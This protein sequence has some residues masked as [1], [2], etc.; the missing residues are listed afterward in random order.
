LAHWCRHLVDSPGSGVLRDIANENRWSA[1]GNLQAVTNPEIEPPEERTAVDDTPA[2]ELN[3]NTRGKAGIARRKSEF[4]SLQFD[5][6]S[7]SGQQARVTFSADGSFTVFLLDSTTVAEK[8][9]VLHRQESQ[10]SANELVKFDKL[11]AATDNLK[12]TNVNKTNGA[13]SW[14]ESNVILQRKKQTRS[15]KVRSFPPGSPYKKLIL[16]VIELARREH[17]KLPDIPWEGHSK[18]LFDEAVAKELPVLEYFYHDGVA[19]L[20]HTGLLANSERQ[21]PS[22]IKLLKKHGVVCLNGSRKFRRNGVW[23][24]RRADKGANDPKSPNF[25]LRYRDGMTLYTPKTKQSVY[26]SYFNAS[27]VANALNR[28]LGKPTI[29]V[30]LGGREFKLLAPTD[31]TNIGGVNFNVYTEADW[32]LPEKNGDKRRIPLKLGVSNS[33]HYFY[34]DGTYYP[35]LETPDG[36]KHVL[37]PKEVQKSSV[38]GSGRS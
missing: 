12:N 32:V 9:K 27:G 29:P 22:T 38:A 6:P 24:Y 7:S 5:F 23:I 36:K 19:H 25:V 10:L 17:E 26:I 31:P 14:I 8:R 30:D 28:V 2:D 3:E 4:D 34:G 20:S 37:V 18:K 15:L 16:F 33:I 35:T 1:A 11:L 21:L 13:E